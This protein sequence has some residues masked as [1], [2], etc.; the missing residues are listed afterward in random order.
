MNV[1]INTNT[2]FSLDG[3]QH[4]IC[5]IHEHHQQYEIR[6]LNDCRQSFI[7]YSGFA[8]AFSQRRLILSELGDTQDTKINPHSSAHQ[9]MLLTDDEKAIIDRRHGYLRAVTTAEGRLIK[10]REKRVYLVKEHGKDVGDKDCVSEATVVRWYHR[11]RAHHFDLLALM[12]RF[13]DRGNRNSRLHPVVARVVDELIKDEYLTDQRPTVEA[14]YEGSLKAKFK[15]DPTL[16][17][18]SLP[19]IKCL[20]R[21][22]ANIGEY[23]KT[24]ARKGYH[25]AK[26]RFPSGRKVDK[27]V[28]FLERVEIDHT[29]LDVLIVGEDGS[30]IGRAYITLLIDVYTRMIVGFYIATHDINTRSVLAAVRHAILPKDHILQKLD[31]IKNTW[32]CF[33]VFAELVTDNGMELHAKNTK[34]TLATLGIDYGWCPKK[35]PT[36]KGTVERVLGRLNHE[37]V[38]QLPGTTFSNYIDA[39]A[40]PSEK[41][42]CLTF[43]RLTALVYAWVVDDYHIDV[44]D[45]LKMSPRA[46]FDIN[47]HRFPP[48]RLP[49]SIDMLEWMLWEKHTR[50]LQKNGVTRDL[51]T[52]QSSELMG[53]AKQSG[54][55][56]AVDVYVDPDDLSTIRLSL[57]GDGKY[58]EVRCVDDEYIE[59]GISQVEHD[60][61][62]IQAK[63]ARKTNADATMTELT[64]ARYVRRKMIEEAKYEQTSK[65]KSKTNKQRD[66]K[67]RNQNSDHVA[68]TRSKKPDHK[69]VFSDAAASAKGQLTIK[70][71]EAKYA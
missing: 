27:P 69:N 24:L 55:G 28:F 47:S 3:I 20:Y 62:K 2:T 1:C 60:A 67:D 52:Y 44:H 37:L 35:T 13:S 31:F 34:R 33:G 68:G 12:P 66:H 7:T 10:S 49:A 4:E 5:G 30:V 54:F 56:I 39:G 9:M 42:A 51:L 70:K 8:E 22:I 11:W 50:T 29:P 48:P 45:T 58:I 71:L 14:I 26:N 61:L 63:K 65:L 15:F 19:S 46:F 21:K 41:Y 38:H 17:G 53:I 32:P 25:D 57:A 6:R 18:Q 16:M 59:G 43:D 40:Y 64:A 36:L 23:S